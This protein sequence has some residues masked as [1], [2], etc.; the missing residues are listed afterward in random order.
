MSDSAPFK[1]LLNI[2]GFIVEGYIR[3]TSSTQN[4]TM[5]VHCKIIKFL[6]HQLIHTMWNLNVYTKSAKHTFLVISLSSF[7]KHYV[8]HTVC[9]SNASMLIWHLCFCQGMIQTYNLWFLNQRFTYSL[10]ENTRMKFQLVNNFKWIQPLISCLWIGL[11]C[12]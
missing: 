12:S 2:R 1:T 4:Q 10:K 11:K 8:N 5:F 9:W 3:S 7:F 6:K